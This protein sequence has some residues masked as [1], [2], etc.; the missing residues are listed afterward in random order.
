MWILGI[1]F[2]VLAGYAAFWM[3]IGGAILFFMALPYICAIAVLLIGLGLSI[4]VII[5]PVHLVRHY[6]KNYD[7]TL[8]TW[9]KSYTKYLNGGAFNER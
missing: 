6:Y 8:V 2:I 4:I 9:W 3:I 1:A 7:A 5:A